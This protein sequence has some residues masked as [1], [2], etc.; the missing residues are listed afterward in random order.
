MELVNIINLEYRYFKQPILLDVNLKINQHEKILLIG[1]N[2]A[3]KSTLLRVMSGMHMAS[4]FKEFKILDKYSPHDQFDGLAYLGN[5]WV[6]NI[7][8]MGPSPYMADIKA[9]DMSKK[10][11]SNYKKR[12]NQLVE[13]LEIN[14]DWKMHKISDGQRKR[15]QIM[16]SLLKPFRF[17]LIDE[18]LSELDIV[19]RDKFFKYLIDEC[20]SRKGAFIYATHVFD[21]VETWATHVCYISGGKCSG[22]IPINK[23]IT[24]NNL[25]NSVKKKIINDP[26]RSENTIIFDK[27]LLGAQGGYGSGR[28]NNL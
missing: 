16:L 10:L 14:L 20:K 2:G 24:D 15:V 7:S 12:R 11:Q 26:D 8:F 17:V 25:Y 21:D 4:N 13:V 3:G 22:K 5:R 6:R 27:K 28:C 1:P 9:G 18:F 19:V 23:F